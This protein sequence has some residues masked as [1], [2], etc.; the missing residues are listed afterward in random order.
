MTIQCNDGLFSISREKSEKIIRT[1]I[2]RKMRER[3]KLER[4]LSILSGE[5]NGKKKRQ[6]REKKIKGEKSRIKV[7]F[8]EESMFLVRACTRL[9]L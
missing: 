2:G 4:L 9:T 6:H 1:R 7:N 3:K 5:K 8:L